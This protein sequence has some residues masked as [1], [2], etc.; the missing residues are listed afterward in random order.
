MNNT[1]F[2]ILAYLAN[3]PNRTPTQLAQAL[4]RNQ[5][6]IYRVLLRAKTHNWVINQGS[7]YTLTDQGWKAIAENHPTPIEKN[8]TP[9]P[10]L[11]TK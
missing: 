6:Q 2:E 9:P 10:D 1:Y 3:K 5:A 7:Q 4:N 11:A 8:L